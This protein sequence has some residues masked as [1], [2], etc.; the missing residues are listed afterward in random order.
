MVPTHLS[1]G[2]L[3]HW[4]SKMKILWISFS[5]FFL[6]LASIAETRSHKAHFHGEGRF[7]LAVEG[8]ELEIEIEIPAHDIVGFEHKPKSDKQK[9][10]LK[11]AKKKLEK[12]SEIVAIAKKAKCKSTAINVKSSLKENDEE[13]HHEE[14]ESEGAHSEFHIT[15]K[16]RCDE[17]KYLNSVVLNLFKWFPIVKELK[18][19]AVTKDGQFR[20]EL[21]PNQNTFKFTK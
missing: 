4:S 6:P 2:F 12:A 15:Y 21:T 10:A 19:Q 17:P 8:N 3:E 13:E 5:L 18:G 16:F 11:V 1:R 20:K 9:K 7:T 14:E